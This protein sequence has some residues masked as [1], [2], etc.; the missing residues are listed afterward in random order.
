LYPK[1]VRLRSYQGDGS[2]SRI[3]DAHKHP[4]DGER[5]GELELIVQGDRGTLLFAKIEATEQGSIIQTWL[6]PSVVLTKRDQARQI[7]KGC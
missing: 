6:A 3:V 2:G 1:Q 5:P 7:G 4:A